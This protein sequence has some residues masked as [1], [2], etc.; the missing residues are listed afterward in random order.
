MSPGLA[1]LHPELWSWHLPESHLLHAHSER[2]RAVPSFQVT[3]ELSRDPGTGYSASHQR[4]KC[5]EARTVDYSICLIVDFSHPPPGRE[6]WHCT[7]PQRDRAPVSRRLHCPPVHAVRPR[8]GP[9][10]SNCRSCRQGLPTGAVN[11]APRYGQQTNRGNRYS[12]RRRDGK[13]P[14]TSDP[15]FIPKVHFGPKRARAR[16]GRLLH[17]CG[18]CPGHSRLTCQARH[19]AACSP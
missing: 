16:R 8:N 3:R 4:P 17:G 18:V 2:R 7:N 15:A 12:I 19:P 6:I 9:R 10:R 14:G 5:S 11:D 13:V 1:P